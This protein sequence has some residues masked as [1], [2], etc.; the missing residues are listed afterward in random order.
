L[1]EVY[2]SFNP[3]NQ[4]YLYTTSKVEHL[5]SINSLGYIKETADGIAFLAFDNPLEGRDPLYRVY[6]RESKRRIYT[7]DE[8]EKDALLAD[9][10]RD[11]LDEGIAYYIYKTVEDEELDLL[12]H[13]DY[14]EIS[15]NGWSFWNGSMYWKKGEYAVWN[16]YL[17]EFEKYTRLPS[18]E[19]ES[20]L[21]LSHKLIAAFDPFTYDNGLPVEVDTSYEESGGMFAISLSKHL[22]PIE[23]ISKLFA[24]DNNSVGTFGDLPIAMF[25]YEHEDYRTVFGNVEYEKNFLLFMKMD[26]FN[27][28]VDIINIDQVTKNHPVKRA[29]VDPYN[30]QIDERSIILYGEERNFDDIGHVALFLENTLYVNPFGIRSSDIYVWFDANCRPNTREAQKYL[31]E[32]ETVC[33]GG[34]EVEREVEDKEVQT[35]KE[36]LRRYNPAPNYTDGIRSIIDVGYSSQDIHE[37]DLDWYKRFYIKTPR[38]CQGADWIREVAPLN[39]KDS[40]EF[41]INGQDPLGPCDPESIRD[42]LYLATYFMTLLPNNY[43]DYKTIPPII[44][45]E[46]QGFR[47]DSYINGTNRAMRWNNVQDLYYIMGVEN[48]STVSGKWSI[49]QRFMLNMFENY[50]TI[51]LDDLPPELSNF[52]PLQYIHE[53]VVAY[54]VWTDLTNT[55]PIDPSDTAYTPGGYNYYEDEYMGWEEFKVVRAYKQPE[56]FN[57]CDPN[58]LFYFAEEVGTPELPG[59]DPWQELIYLGGEVSITDY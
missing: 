4:D 17:S 39:M 30:I 57:K 27:S 34:Q 51:F 53:L 7:T 14:Y 46:K 50:E 21:Y 13:G 26:K 48:G 33:I 24:V 40:L 38:K 11:I 29:Y 16:E 59:A 41:T 2:R 45:L 5:N 31:Q 10:E 3:E 12:D 56:R 25:A 19:T 55:I 22:L 36:T 43:I 49:R 15:S 18:E 37:K 42:T 58:G 44:T 9:E 35:F 54:D 6:D 8:A 1:I 47:E 28:E 52:V 20:D 23:D 32:N